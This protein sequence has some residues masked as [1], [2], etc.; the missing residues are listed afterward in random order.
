MVSLRPVILVIFHAGVG[1]VLHA[2]A[3]RLTHEHLMLPGSPG[4]EPLLDPPPHFMEYG[5]MSSLLQYHRLEDD[6]PL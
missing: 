2:S 1:K 4:V 3:Q 5:D 6:G